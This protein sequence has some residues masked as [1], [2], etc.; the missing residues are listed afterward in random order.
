[1]YFILSIWQKCHRKTAP[2]GARMAPEAPAGGVASARSASWRQ[3]PP[4]G[5]RKHRQLAPATGASG[6]KNGAP[7]FFILQKRKM[8]PVANFFEMA[9]AGN[10]TIW[11]NRQLAQPPSG[12]IWRHLAPAGGIFWRH[13]APSGAIWHHLAPS[14]ATGASNTASWFIWR[15]MAV[16]PDGGCARWRYRQ[17]APFQ[18]NSQLAPFSVFAK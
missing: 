7:P 18:K 13:L 1:M 12:A 14:G 16:A 6:D 11:G 17:L 4:A 2:S 10:T 9:P 15:Q 5:A 3:T 8:A